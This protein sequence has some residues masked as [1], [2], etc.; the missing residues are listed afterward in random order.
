MND[1]FQ[2]KVWTPVW[3]PRFILAKIQND[4]VIVKHC[5]EFTK[6]STGRGTI[7]FEIG[8]QSLKILE[9]NIVELTDLIC[10]T[11]F[12]QFIIEKGEMKRVRKCMSRDTL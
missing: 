10:E 5:V 6:I 12:S 2:T 1:N 11:F 3:S 7:E 8:Y 4:D 9:R